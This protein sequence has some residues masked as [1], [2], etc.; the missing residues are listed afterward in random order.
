MKFVVARQNAHDLSVFHAR[1]A[2]YAGD[3]LMHLLVEAICAQLDEVSMPY[4]TADDSQKIVVVGGT[5]VVALGGWR[6]KTWH[7]W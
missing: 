7:Y 1:Q 5:G 4:S 2:H 6:L 3:L